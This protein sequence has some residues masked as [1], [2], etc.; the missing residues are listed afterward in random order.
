MIA[1]KK[2]FFTGVGLLAAF[3]VVLILIF[4]PMFKGQN[5]L[6]YLDSLYNAISK[7]SAYYI[8]AVKK[9][10]SPFEG[11]AAKATLSMA[12]E[13][14]AEQT[15]LLFEAAGTEVNIKGKE[16]NVSGDLGRMLQ[17]CLSDADHMYFNKGEKVS[18]KYGY[19]AKRVLFNWWHAL[20]EMDK[21]FSR[22]KEFKSAKIVSLVAKK[23]VETSYN[24]YGIEPQKITGRMGVV[25][26]SLVFYVI[27]TLWYGFSIM[28]MFEG[29]GMRLG[30]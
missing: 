2:E 15:A 23:A 25:V 11:K 30:H 7:G 18:N 16:L 29:W 14:Q 19:D 22:Q 8:P 12:G 21:S 5:G 20:K 17:N 1:N 24:Y 28:F 3:V 4:S 13:K 26:F 27:Y 6:E 9:D 10:V